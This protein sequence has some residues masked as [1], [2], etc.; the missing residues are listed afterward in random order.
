MTDR[1]RSRRG[2]IRLL[3]GSAHGRGNM[4]A[5]VVSVRIDGEAQAMVR[6]ALRF[7]APTT[8][9]A[10]SRMVSVNFRLN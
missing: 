6:R 4:F 10:R 9:A 8:G 5:A 2:G 1:F 7:P 3:H